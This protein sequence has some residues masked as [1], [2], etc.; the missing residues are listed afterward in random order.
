MAEAIGQLRSNITCCSNITRILRNKKAAD[1]FFPLVFLT[2]PSLVLVIVRSYFVTETSLRDLQEE[3][4]EEEGEREYSSLLQKITSR[5][6]I[7]RSISAY[8]G[9]ACRQLVYSN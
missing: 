5:C 3:E 1:S 8:K 2:L 4:E 7:E 6:L 9:L